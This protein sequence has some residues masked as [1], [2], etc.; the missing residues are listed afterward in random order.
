MKQTHQTHYCKMEIKSV[1]IIGQDKVGAIMQALP[2]LRHM[3]CFF[4]FSVLKWFLLILFVPF[5][6]ALDY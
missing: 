5:V 2:V 1:S 4:L 3:S 6:C